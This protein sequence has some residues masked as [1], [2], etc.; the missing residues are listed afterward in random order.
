MQGIVEKNVWD[1]LTFILR[2]FSKKSIYDTLLENS[3]RNYNFS[4]RSLL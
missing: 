4:E 1:I 2:C 3:Q